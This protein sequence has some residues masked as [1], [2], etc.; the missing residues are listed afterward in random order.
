MVAFIRKS[1]QDMPRGNKENIQVA[2]FS[3]ISKTLNVSSPEWDVNDAEKQT[4]P[5]KLAR[6]GACLSLFRL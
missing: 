2:G 3:L 5:T 1:V 4:E 6:K